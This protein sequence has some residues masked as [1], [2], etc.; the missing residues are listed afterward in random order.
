MEEQPRRPVRLEMGQSSTGVQTTGTELRMGSRDQHQR[1]TVCMEV[2][3]SSTSA[4][5]TSSIG[6]CT[7]GGTHAVGV[8]IESV[9]KAIEDKS[10]HSSNDVMCS[11]CKMAIVW[12]QNR[13]KKNQTQ[14]KV[15]NQIN[16]LCG[17]LPSPVGDSFI[18]C[19]AISTM[20][21]ISFNIGGKTFDLTV[22]K[23]LM[24][25]LVRWWWV[26]PAGGNGVFEPEGGGGCSKQ[27][28]LGRFSRRAA[29]NGANAAGGSFVHP[30][31][32]GVCP[33]RC[34]EMPKQIEP[35]ILRG[36]T[37]EEYIFST[38]FASISSNNQHMHTLSN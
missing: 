13:L 33:K 17:R 26:D 31:S 4:P 10:S 20:H 5:A 2:G 27:S 7:F 11:A 15:L 32:G 14:E 9:V 35:K 37:P 8:D 22:E 29:G 1:S 6:V 18:D 25:H 30:P 12:M 21:I 3:Q 19:G 28:F 36:F 24:L 34:S 38:I 16:Q 23:R